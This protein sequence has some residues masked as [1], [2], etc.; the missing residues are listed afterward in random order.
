MAPS[1]LGRRR[2]ALPI[3]RPDG[4]HHVL[5]RCPPR[6]PHKQGHREMAGRARNR[7]RPAHLHIATPAERRYPATVLPRRHA[8]PSRGGHGR[9]SG[10]R[11]GRKK[12]RCRRSQATA[13]VRPAA[14][15]G[16]DWKRPARRAGAKPRPRPPRGLPSKNPRRNRAVRF[17]VPGRASPKPL[18]PERAALA[19]QL[20]AATRKPRRPSRHQ[21]K[22]RGAVP[23][24]VRGT[25]ARRR[26]R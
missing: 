1:H 24:H 13:P 21:P 15:A 10:P 11:A 5:G 18:F 12:P 7:G 19:F 6:G 26:G 20:Q 16:R 4:L 9:R 25:E 23:S 22:A 2:D 14:A 17:P 3:R 8:R